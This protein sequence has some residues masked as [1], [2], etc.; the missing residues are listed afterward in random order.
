VNTRFSRAAQAAALL[1]T[2]AMSVAACGGST[3]GGSGA[4]AGP[5]PHVLSE[6]MAAFKAAKSVHVIGTIGEQGKHYTLNLSMTRAGGLSGQ[7]AQAGAGFALLSTHGSTYIKMSHA[8]L[9]YLKLPAAA[10]A[11][12]CGKYFKLTPAQASQLT[13]DISMSSLFR[14][15]H[16]PPPLRYGGTATINGQAAWVLRGSRGAAYVAAHGTPYLLRLIV[17]HQ[18]QLNFAQWNAVTIPGPPPASQV[19]DLSQ[20][21]RLG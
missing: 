10:C 18:G 15:L 20:L 7:M 9:Q 11:L 21:Q 4:P 12:M 14:A 6:A 17:P 2:I 19:V 3:S 16:S 8:F 1:G 5:G 13:G